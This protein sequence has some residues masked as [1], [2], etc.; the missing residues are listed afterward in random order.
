MKLA[1][2][3]SGK[4]FVCIY[5][6]YHWQ[7]GKLKN[8]GR[9]HKATPYFKFLALISEPVR[10]HQ[11]N[12]MCITFTL[13]KT[14]MYNGHFIWCSTH[15]TCQSKIFRTEGSKKFERKHMFLHGHAAMHSLQE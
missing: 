5:F 6:T 2:N 11:N 1:G 13:L 9:A 4:K 14:R 12:Q 8:K 7:D 15:D 10:R 3:T